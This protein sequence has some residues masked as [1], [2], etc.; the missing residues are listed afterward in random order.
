[1]S[2]VKR[3]SVSNFKAIAERT[4]DF[5]GC[6]AIITAGNNKG[7]T[8][9]LR[10]LFDRLRG[11]KPEKILKIGESEGFAECELTTGE[12][13]RWEFKGNGKEKLIY[14]SS[15][16]IKSSVTREICNTFFPAIFD[17]DAFLNAQPAIQR[18]MLQRLVGLDFTDVDARYKTAYD[19]REAKNRRAYED[20]I[21]FEAVKMPQHIDSVDTTALLV[22]KEAIRKELNDLY[23]ANKAHNQ[24]LRN[25]YDEMV[26]AA[27]KEFNAAKELMDVQYA[28]VKDA[29]WC[30]DKLIKLGYTGGKQIQTWIDS[31]QVIKKVSLR[32][33]A[34]PVYIEELPSDEKIIEI[35][36]KINSANEVNRKAQ[37]YKD[38]EALRQTKRTSDFDAGVADK[39]VKVIE[40]E[41]LDMIK[42][43]TMPEGF[44]FSDDGILYNELPFT[45]Q[46]LSSSGI[47]IAALKLA[48]M[49]LG[50][51][52]TLHFDASFLD[53]KSLAEIEAWAT[54]QDLQLL[55]ERPDFEGGEIEYQI[56][57]N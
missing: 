26:I 14:I 47:Y 28:N 24:T 44:S 12:K 53:K 34:K 17:V 38:W 4:A 56:I 57:N 49:T 32:E 15:K 9:L 21:K 55:I 3:I 13:F 29:Q 23:V 6:T 22:A 42:G 43:A 40:K 37:M 18:R 54:K 39:K 16:D 11:I 7:K 35:D 50:E 2:K 1:M 36:A 46:Q 20:K 51:V 10:G 8:T 30:L 52:K 25:N 5:E 27:Q 31:L 45:R 33:I 19:D 48:S 41:R